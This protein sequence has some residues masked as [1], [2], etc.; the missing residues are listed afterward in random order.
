MQDTVMQA[1]ISTRPLLMRFMMK[2]NKVLSE[3]TPTF[4]EASAIVAKLPA[5]IPGGTRF[6]TFPLPLLLP[7][8]GPIRET[9]GN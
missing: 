2:I 3:S 5:T 8:N 6:L 1:L 7:Q 9:I 4:M